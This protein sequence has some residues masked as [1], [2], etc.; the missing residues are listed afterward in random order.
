MFGAQKRPGRDAFWGSIVLDLEPGKW[1]PIPS[2]SADTQMLAYSL[3]PNAQLAFAKDGADNF[4]VMSQS[5]GRH[6]LTWLSDAAQD[7]FGGEVPRGLRLRDQGSR[8]DEQ[9]GCGAETRRSGLRVWHCLLLPRLGE[10][11]SRVRGGSDIGNSPWESSR[12]PRRCSDQIS[13]QESGGAAVRG[14]PV[15]DRKDCE[16][17]AG[18]HT[19][20]V[21][22]V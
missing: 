17:H 8:R 16:L 12:V 4:F 5:G 7:Y 3:S 15:I 6:R 22:D 20:L 9:G 13:G 1:L 10:R 11:D 2:V 21:I 19:E 14:E 18:E